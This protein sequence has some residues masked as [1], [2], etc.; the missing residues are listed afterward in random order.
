MFSVN[1]AA[2]VEDECEEGGDGLISVYINKQSVFIP[3]IKGKPCK[4][5]DCDCL[6]LYLL[7]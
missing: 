6:A 5:V 2:D 4:H 1:A 7:M 3:T